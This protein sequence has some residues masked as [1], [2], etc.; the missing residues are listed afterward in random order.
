MIPKVTKYP[1]FEPNQVLTSTQ[2]NDLF[3]YT[4]EQN[5]LTR[6]NLIGIGIVCG[7]DIQT[8]P[9][10]N[11]TITRGCGVSSEG[12]LITQDNDV[13]YSFIKPYDAPQ[14]E[15]YPTLQEAN[16]VLKFLP[17]FELLTALPSGNADPAIV[18]L[19]PALL[20][21]MVVLLLVELNQ[22][23]NKNCLPNSCDDKGTTV[24]VFIKTLLIKK[25]DIDT[26]KKPILNYT[27]KKALKVLKMPRFDVPRSALINTADVVKAYKRILNKGFIE[28]IVAVL[29]QLYSTYK[30]L[31]PTL[32]AEFAQAISKIGAWKY[33]SLGG[34]I[35]DKEYEYQYYYDFVRDLIDTYMEI[36]LKAAPVLAN[37]CPD[38][39]LFPRHLLLGEALNPVAPSQYRHYFI[40]SPILAKETEC[41]EEIRFLVQRMSLMIQAFPSIVTTTKTVGNVINEADIRIT[42][43][44]MGVNLSEK[45]IPHYYAQ[46]SNNGK[47]LFEFWNADL[48][49]EGAANQNLS[50]RAVEY[51]GTDDFVTDPL[52][53]ELEAY[54]F[55]NIEG[56][57]G[58]NFQSVLKFLTMQRQKYRLPFDIVAIKTGNQADPVNNAAFECY[59]DDLD[60]AFAV[61]KEEIKIECSPAFNAVSLAQVTQAIISALDV[62][63]KSE[64]QA[65]WNTYNKRVDD[66]QRQFLLS[67]YTEKHSSIQHKS[68]VPVGGTFVIVY[69]GPFKPPTFV[70][71][72]NKLSGF[73][74]DAGTFNDIRINKQALSSIKVISQALDANNAAHKQIV[75]DAIK[76]FEITKQ[77]SVKPAMTRPSFTLP[78]FD[79]FETKPLFVATTPIDV[80]EGI[81]FAD[82][83][84][85]YKVSSD[86]APAVQYI[87]SE[88]LSVSLSEGVCA[89]DNKTF[90]VEFDVIGGNA[91][92]SYTV[93][94]AINVNNISGSSFKHTFKASEAAKIIVKDAH[95]NVRS[96]NV[97]AKDCKSPCDLPCGG[98]M[99][100]CRYAFP[101]KA[102]PSAVFVFASVAKVKFTDETGNVTDFDVDVKDIKFSAKNIMKVLN[103]KLFAEINAN[104]L[105]KK[106]SIVLEYDNDSDSVLI[107]KPICQSVV[108]TMPILVGDITY[109]YTVIAGELDAFKNTLIV[110][111]GAND[112]VFAKFGCVKWNQCNNEIPGNECKLSPFEIGR[113][114]DSGRVS[115][116]PTAAVDTVSILWVF[117][118]GKRIEFSTET[119]P[120]IPFPLNVPIRISAWIRDKAA[121]WTFVSQN[122]QGT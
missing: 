62:K 52:S 122:T 87:V 48:S 85:P 36:K 88:P 58:R 60:T 120:K 20:V 110:N 114:P 34:L 64:L 13:T 55:F 1:Q 91:P 53:F 25:S 43:S 46:G 84:L 99:E 65:L 12:Y 35:L 63:C 95:D 82:F 7:L 16:G 9:T 5:R 78:P 106:N 70:F 96:I 42:P 32:N 30:F 111:Q 104:P 72:G 4:D 23:T 117:E 89:A 56:H 119:N 61:L 80:T 26:F 18:P 54:N 81:V 45:S 107:T 109:N 11:I 105:F 59:F 29:E 86:G 67:N 121:C 40:P 41:V 102:T 21:D 49:K 74:F 57:V 97:P 10:G 17:V 66:L 118:Q 77:I 50:Y 38:A 22:S 103:D 100:R 101:F 2:L 28:S 93:E 79:R 47:Q 92:Y 108:F 15:V 73:T 39:T 69:D 75:I 6:T 27:S 76:Q 51:N 44:K 112:V 31:Y 14:K 71:N 94:G 37:C 33:D 90:T 24:S 68:G 98:Q 8:I 3:G 113:D 83:Y 116:K 19:I 115:V